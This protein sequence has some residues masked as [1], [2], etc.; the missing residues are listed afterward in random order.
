MRDNC[1]P[2]NGKTRGS[3]AI[4]RGRALVRRRTT[5]NYAGKFDNSQ[6]RDR[7][8]ALEAAYGEDQ[9]DIEDWV[10]Y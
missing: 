8:S 6:I 5:G 3:E 9:I 7:I 2:D 10:F 4:C 1:P